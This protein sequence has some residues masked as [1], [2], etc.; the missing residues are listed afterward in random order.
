M[1]GQKTLAERIEALE[2]KEVLANTKV[3]K[4]KMPRK[5]KASKGKLKK[6]FIGVFRVDENKNATFEKQKVEGNVFVTKDGTYHATDGSEVLFWEGKFPFVIQK[7]WKK[8]PTKLI[9]DD[10]KNETYGQKY[11]MARLLGDVIKVKKKLGGI[12]L[13]VGLGILALIAFQFLGG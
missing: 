8:N 3:K 4:V 6:G 5:G 10:E 9:K 11:I 1:E 12:G 2:G 7:T 13:I